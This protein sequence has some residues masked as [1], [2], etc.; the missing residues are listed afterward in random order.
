MPNL[1]ETF[2]ADESSLHGKLIKTV[3][4]HWSAKA[5]FEQYDH[6]LR[7]SLKTILQDYLPT[8]KHDVVWDDSP[9]LIDKCIV[10][11]DISFVD[12]N[13]NNRVMN[14]NIIPTGTLIQ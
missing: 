11:A 8:I 10:S 12:E 4:E 13:G 14:L 6:V 7:E 2:I 3:I 9:E 5:L 1:E